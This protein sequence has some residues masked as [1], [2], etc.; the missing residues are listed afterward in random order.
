MSSELV[1]NGSYCTLYT[2]DLVMVAE[3]LDQL[4]TRLKNWKDG[5]E[6]KGIKVIVGKSKVL[7]SKHVSKSKIESVKFP[8]GV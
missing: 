8:Y 1:A 7:C 5:L 4:K 3:S 2:N 6:E